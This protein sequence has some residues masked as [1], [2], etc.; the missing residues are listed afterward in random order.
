MRIKSLHL[1]RG[2]HSALLLK[3][4]MVLLL[5]LSSTLLLA[6]ETYW[7]PVIVGSTANMVV[8]AIVQIDGVD[9]TDPQLELAAFCAGECRGAVLLTHFVIPGFLTITCMT[10][11][12]LVI[13][14]KN[15]PSNCMT[16]V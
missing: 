8:T 7:T 16:I 1:T 5:C 2:L 15:S 4:V 13:Q 3:R 6:Q 9:Q 14:D 11:M 12:C 10:L